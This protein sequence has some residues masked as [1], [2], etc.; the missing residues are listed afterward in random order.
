MAPA[1]NPS[2]AVA[3][4]GKTA[5]KKTSPVAFIAAMLVLTG[6]GVGFG[7]LLGLHLQGMV[8]KA[9]K[10]EPKAPAQA[11]SQPAKSA[12]TVPSTAV[13]SLSP[14]VT[15]LGSPERTWIRLEAMLVTD[16][17]PA[18]DPNS[19]ALDAQI[20]EDIVAYLR[21]LALAQIQGAS[22]FQHLR[23]DLKERVRVRSG[24]RVRD[25]LVQSLIVE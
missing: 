18:P 6:I 1:P 13:R 12:Q 14:I 25:I 19:G 20:T 23:E 15:N 11:S 10:G 17:E 24:G 21:T 4:E 2:E 3:A 8:E 9:K 7:G 16:V 22:G 5:G